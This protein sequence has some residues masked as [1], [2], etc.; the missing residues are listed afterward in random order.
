MNGLSLN[1]HRRSY[2]GGSSIHAVI[3][4]MFHVKPFLQ[5]ELQ[6]SIP[7]GDDTAGTGVATPALSTRSHHSTFTPPLNEEA[8]INAY[9]ADIHGIVPLL[10]EDYF[11]GVWQHGERCDRPWLALLNMVLVLGSLAVGDDESSHIYYTRAQPYLN[12]DLLGTG[13]LE[14][15]QALCLL[16]GLYLH[17]KN[18]P[19]T[20][21]AIMGLAYRIAIGLG[22]HRQPIDLALGGTSVQ[23]AAQGA[24]A[25][26]WQ[27]Q[28]R[29][30]IWW[31]LFC[32][33]TWGSMSLG[34]PTLGR[35]DPKTMNVHPVVNEFS[36]VSNAAISLD[37]AS[38]FCII[39]T[40][41]QH[42]LAH[43]S[44]MKIDEVVTFDGEVQSWYNDL[45]PQLL[46]LG[47]CPASLLSAQ[48]IM[49]NRY[50]NL[51]LLLYRTVLL[52]YA[53]AGV[54]LEILPALEQDAVRACR[55]I[56]CEAIEQAALSMQTSSKILICSAVWYLYQASMALL[57]G[58]MVDPNHPDSSKWRQAVEKAISLLASAIPWSRSAVR[59][60]RVVES[61]LRVCDVTPASPS[62]AHDIGN[63]E[64]LPGEALWDLL[65]L[66]MFTDEGMFVAADPSTLCTHSLLWSSYVSVQDS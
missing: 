33:D 57:L 60:K 27:P 64:G 19:N 66:D 49:R 59:S 17:I 63:L 2:L 18:T 10:D 51:R 15:L 23:G 21:Y 29:R 41:I 47:Q 61:L 55:D 58:I 52:R 56:A 28:I 38:K 22:L 32:L 62:R 54:Q 25:G 44:P 9:F 34:R 42:R 5:S 30:Q 6:N 53:H 35:W 46:D 7:I 14:S 13:C 48:Y 4:A 1:V 12:F 65:G 37:S 16:G 20:A 45:P 26:H 40:K 3:R 24:L 31:S 11:R 36:D 50:H 39:A 43:V 8:A